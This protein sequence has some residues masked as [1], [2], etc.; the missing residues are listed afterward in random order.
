MNELL[1]INQLLLINYSF[2]QLWSSA[3]FLTEL[4]MHWW[5]LGTCPCGVESL[6]GV[7]TLLELSWSRT[8]SV[9]RGEAEKVAPRRWYLTG[10]LNSRCKSQWKENIQRSVTQEEVEE[11]SHPIGNWEPLEVLEQ[12]WWELE[13]RHGCMMEDCLEEVALEARESMKTLQRGLGCWWCQSRWT[14]GEQLDGH[15]EFLEDRGYWTGTG[16][17]GLVKS[18]PLELVVLSFSILLS[19]KCQS[20]TPN[21]RRQTRSHYSLC[22]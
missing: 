5:A 13:A 17:E 21:F 7:G 6:Q 15:E 18:D 14:Q 8:L 9:M 12:P 20:Y 22:L 19:P 11:H 10:D 1:L 3:S 2:I 4:E 16:R